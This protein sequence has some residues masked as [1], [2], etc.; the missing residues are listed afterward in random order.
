M[1]DSLKK[2]WQKKSKILFFSMFYLKNERFA[3][4][5]FFVS[6]VSESPRLLTKKRLIRSENQCANSQPCS[7]LTDGFFLSPALLICIVQQFV[8]GSA[9]SIKVVF[10]VSSRVTL[11]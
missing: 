5:L 4:S 3:H 10:V 11:F 9:M 1:S 8:V 7:N 6:D 2:I